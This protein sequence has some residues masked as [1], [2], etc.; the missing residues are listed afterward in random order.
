MATV[1]YKGVMF[2]YGGSDTQGFLCDDL[3][4]LDYRNPPPCFWGNI[5][6]SYLLHFY[7]LIFDRRK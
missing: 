3:W 2:V 4:A 5:K 1:F 6:A 7:I